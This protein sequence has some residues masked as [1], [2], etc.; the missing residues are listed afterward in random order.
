MDYKISQYAKIQGVTPRTIWRWIKNG[1]IAIRKTKTGRVRVILDEI[2]EKNVAVYARVSSSENK[3]NLERQKDRLVS[4]CNAKGY[5]VAKIVTEIGS[6]LNDSRPK[7]E[8]LLIDKEITTIVVEHKD[9]LCRFGT[10]YIEKLLK[11]QNRE[12]EIVNPVQDERSDL[13]EDFVSIITSFTARLYGQRRSK[14]KTEKLI[15]K[16]ET[17]I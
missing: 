6:G 3:D 9:R 16:L 10:N 5:K 11:M 14:R 15:E 7:L 17:E 12:I 8:N 4:Y 1:D 2:K 13:M